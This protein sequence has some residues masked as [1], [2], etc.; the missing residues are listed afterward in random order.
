MDN[1]SDPTPPFPD[2]LG[3]DTNTVPPQEVPPQE[4]PP[5]DIPVATSLFDY[6]DHHTPPPTPAEIDSTYGYDDDPLAYDPIL[7][8][9]YQQPT[10]EIPPHPIHASVSKF[11]KLSSLM[12]ENVNLKKWLKRLNEKQEEAVQII[13]G[14]VLVLAGAGTGKTRVLT[15]RLAKLVV[16]G[17]ARPWE[18]LC[19]TFTNKA[20][21]EMRE[22]VSD[23][24]FPVSIDG[25]WIGTFHSISAR[26]LRRHGAVLGLDSDFVI[27]DTDDQVRLLK[28]VMDD[29][30]FDIQD[31]RWPPR[32]VAGHINRWK[33]KAW[34]PERV[35]ADEAGGVLNGKGVLVYTEYQ[36]R[37]LTLNACDF[38]DLLLHCLTLFTKHSEIGQKYQQD[39]KY[40]QVDEYQDTNVAQYLWLR[41]LAMGHKNIFCVGDDDQSIYGWRGAEVANMLKFE[42]DFKNAPIIRLEQNYRS[43][44][45]ILE[46]ANALIA[47]NQGRM[48]KNLFTDVSD[49]ENLKLNGY[50]NDEEESHG[51]A[52]EVEQ[53][54]RRKI[55]LSDMA[56]LVRTGAQTRAFEERFMH[57][58]IP[59][60]VI[61][62]HRFYEREESR[63]ALAYL[64]LINQP[65]DSLAF[66][67]I[68]NKPARKIGAT[69][70]QH[71]Q[72][73]ARK[74]G[75]SLWQASRMALDEKHLKSAAH[76]AL[77]KAIALFEHWRATYKNDHPE[78]P[79]FLD[80][81][82]EESGYREMWQQSKKLEA[83]GK[84]ENLNEMLYHVSEFTTLEQYLEHVSLVMET[85]QNAGDDAISIMTLHGAK[86]LEFDV[87]FL[88]G[89]DE[90]LFPSN[91]SMDENGVAGLEEERRLAYVGITRAKRFS[92]ISTVAN[93]RMFI[94]DS[95]GKSVMRY[96][97][98]LPSRFIYE[99]PQNYVDDR[100]DTGL[101]AGSGGGR[102]EDRA[103]L[104]HRGSD[105]G[106]AN[107]GHSNVGHS[108]VGRAGFGGGYDAPNKRHSHPPPNP[109]SGGAS[110]FFAGCRI[111]HQK[112]G[113]GTVMVIDGEHL[114]IDF[115]H[116]GRKKVVA[117]FVE[118][119]D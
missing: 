72:D 97:D 28:Q 25:L 32:A 100:T 104:Y 94:K 74:H 37:L 86:G 106:Y 23:A 3:Q 76:N 48:G 102:A 105:D 47:N 73:L 75:I 61:G 24:S 38:G 8:P 7:T 20:A 116:A 52:D 92:H 41:Y 43:T 109:L 50:W 98:S 31:K 118:K 4:V 53:Y 117:S 58:N 35:P 62:G 113:D 17:I 79:D 67:R 68:I 107:G 119:K 82:L 21:T 5:Q 39:F 1:H 45:Q 56:V 93:R 18:V 114:T 115:D 22:R 54:Q 46:S 87:V 19:V 15:T 40:I 12:Q 57:L 85:E 51:V 55:P 59:C 89:W 103:Q 77:G 111:Y 84:V 30:G 99:L 64:R 14:P 108:N 88:P 10:G 112:F 34:T 91:R 80:R 70:V 13:E 36:K 81:V 60:K 33:D 49:G 29:M 6:G 26:I 66:E 16:E 90:G 11:E 110:D 2:D 63:D 44:T 101:Y 96:V 65:H 95:S 42:D 71:L 69:T 83:Q 27:I 78:L 9:N